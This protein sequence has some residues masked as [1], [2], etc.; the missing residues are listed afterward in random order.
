MLK[1][2][3]MLTLGSIELGL[4]YAI[5][6]FLTSFHNP[7]NVMTIGIVIAL[8]K[9]DKTTVAVT[10]PG[11]TSNSVA[12]IVFITAV[13]VLASIIAVERFNP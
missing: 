11:L 1:L 12:K 2:K 5:Y 8:N 4:P 3:T 13:G 10:N 6:R 7:S 9:V